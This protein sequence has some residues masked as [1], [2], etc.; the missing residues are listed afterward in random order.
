MIRIA[1]IACNEIEDIE[2]IAPIDL[3]RRAGFR[4][5]AI[6]LEKKNSIIL[7]SG[8]KISCDNVIEKTNLDQYNAIY[9]PGGSGH[10]KY[11][12]E[13]WPPRNNEG[14]IRLHK[15]LNKFR[16]EKK[17]I[18]A[19]CAAP[20]LLGSLGMLKGVKTTCYPGYE[21]TFKDTYVDVPCIMDQFIITGRSPSAAFD[22]SYL[23]MEVLGG[24]K[25]VDKIKKETIYYQDK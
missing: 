25:L 7:N 21:A 5:D 1:V 24:K 16:D 18:L 12:I 17:Y 15:Y 13:N 10:K 19:M 8:I 6:S 4:V 23:V 3:W 14:I 9:L 22:F 20:S 2:L 11:F